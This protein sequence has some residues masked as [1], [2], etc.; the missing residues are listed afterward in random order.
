MLVPLA[1]GRPLSVYSCLGWFAQSFLDSL[2]QITARF[3]KSSISILGWESS[4]VIL[5]ST[6]LGKPSHSLSCIGYLEL[7]HP[8]S[9]EYLA[10]FAHFGADVVVGGVCVCTH[11]GGWLSSSFLWEVS[12]EFLFIIKL[13]VLWQVDRLTSEQNI[14]FSL[15]LVLLVL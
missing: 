14:L 13:V 4:A 2:T 6:A 5:L 10:E 12:Y 7:E 9:Q 8:L 11:S 1:Y 15:C 3:K